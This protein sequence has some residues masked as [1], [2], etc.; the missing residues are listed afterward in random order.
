MSMPSP[1]SRPTRA[2]QDGQ[3]GQAEEIEFHQPRLLD[4]LH[5]VLRDEEVRARIAIERH[6]FDQRPV[7][8][9]HT[10]GM[11]GRVA[12]QAFELQRDFQQ[13]GDALV[14]VAQLLQAGL[15]VD[16]LLQGDGLGR[17]VRDQLG[18]PV[19]LPERQA[20]T[21]PTSRTAARACSLPKVMI[22]ATRSA[23]YSL[24]DVVDD[25]VAAFLAEVDVEVRHRHAFG[26]EEALEQQVEAERIERR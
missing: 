10:G 16:R 6:Q 24:A 3:R 26:V 23:P 12:I 21:R 19:H 25:A 4:M 5:R 13:A 20:S 11:R 17:I 2:L 8:D 14:V 1:R 7:A 9:H 18:D 15:A 22:C